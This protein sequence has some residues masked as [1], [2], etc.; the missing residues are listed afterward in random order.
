MTRI[1][2]GTFHVRITP[3][4]VPDDADGT[5]HGHSML[6]KSYFGDLEASAK[7]AMLTAVTKTQGS[8]VYVALE[9]VSG[10]LEGKRGTFSLAH[11]GRMAHGERTQQVEIVPD[12]GSGELAGISGALTIRIAEGQHYYELRY[13]VNE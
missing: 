12:S 11:Y 1:A 7:G 6:D 13:T 4:G 9:R 2:S 10:T 3:S 5:A 8:A